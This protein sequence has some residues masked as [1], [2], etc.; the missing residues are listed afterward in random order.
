MPADIVGDAADRGRSLQYPPMP[1]KKSEQ[2]T[3]RE[4]V[5]HHG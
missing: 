3:T 1:A 4:Q 2:H 5:H